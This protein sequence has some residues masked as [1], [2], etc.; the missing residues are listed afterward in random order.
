VGKLDFEKPQRMD[1]IVRYLVHCNNTFFDENQ[2]P[3]W[4]IPIQVKVGAK[5][6]DLLVETAMVTRGESIGLE[7]EGSPAFKF[8]RLGH[9]RSTHWNGLN[10]VNIKKQAEFLVCSEEMLKKIENHLEIL[11]FLH[12]KYMPMVVPPIPWTSAF[13]GGYLTHK[14]FVMR[15]R[16]SKL[17]RKMLKEADQWKGDFKLRENNGND[18]DF[19]SLGGL[20][21][22]LDDDSLAA[23]AA[24]SSYDEGAEFM[25]EDES[26]AQGVYHHEDVTHQLDVG[27]LGLDETEGES[28]S[29]GS[30][31]RKGMSEVY[32]A[33]NSLGWT[34]WRI[35][36]KV[37]GVVDKVWNS[38]MEELR[39]RTELP[40]RT[41]NEMIPEPAAR[42]RMVSSKHNLTFGTLSES[43]YENALRTRRNNELLRENRENYSQKCDF[44]YKFDTAKKYIEEDA[45]YF[46]HNMDFRGRAYP[47][48]PYLNH[49]GSDLCRSMLKFSD[50]KPMGDRGLRWL[51]IH[52]ANLRGA[53]KMSLDSREE[54][55]KNSLDAILDSAKNPLGGSRWWADAENP[56]QCLATC[57]EIAEALESGSP[58]TF[59][60]SIPVHQDGS[61]NGLQHYAALSRDEEGARSVNLLPCDAPYDVY[62]RVAALVAEAVEK[63][64]HDPSSAY[65]REAI[66]LLGEVDRKLVKQTVMTSVYGVTFIGARQ[67]IASRLKERGWTDKDK[68]YVTSRVAAKLT[69]NA[70]DKAFKNAKETM[71]W[72]GDCASI[73]S[74]SGEPVSWTTPL[75]LPVAQPYRRKKKFVVITNN[76]RLILQ[77]S[78]EADPVSPLK[79]RT[80]FPPNYVHSLDS[81]HLLM[82]ASECHQRGITFAGVHDSFWTH[83]SSIDEMNTVLREKF[84][85]LHKQ[86]LLEN[87][88]NEFQAAHP[89]LRLPPVPELGPLDLEHVKDAPYFFS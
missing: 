82:T 57:F 48:H 55:S 58:A 51:F 23:A 76:Q 85:D 29:A 62:S 65:H 39:Q 30:Y 27:D 16:G 78:N 10:K 86:P 28:F 12:P 22:P 67:Q 34:S 42:F 53:N 74:K 3:T 49:L 24:A 73:I 56:Y 4:G 40:S 88:L 37:F 5:L 41:D 60:S 6:V 17:Q 59:A 36:K 77:K 45:I 35:N 79:Q 11:S 81:S 80:A 66:N 1:S 7:L 61:C 87:L 43:S 68:I 89:K 14:T 63:H 21:S 52:V 8:E 18:N 71:R 44:L 72:L 15:V 13:S 20:A 38:D 83:A 75:G 33:L 2:L 69:M 47:M 31:K 84:I 32:D 54:Y 64:A 70:L 26:G 46:P 25:M 9:G 19:A 50:A